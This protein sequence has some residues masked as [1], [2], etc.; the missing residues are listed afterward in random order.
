MA[1]YIFDT[2]T[3]SKDNPEVI[4]AAWIT[5]EDLGSMAVGEQFC[6]RYQPAGRIALGA[7]ATHHIMDEDLA[8]CPPSSSFALPGDI[9]YLVGHN[10][11][12]DWEVAGC[13]EVK[14]ID[15]LAL[16][17]EHYP[18]AD[19]HT[20]SAMLY[21]LDRPNAREKL[22]SAHSA[23]T[24]VLICRDVLAVMLKG[25]L[26]HIDS[27]EELWQA[28][29]EARIPKVMPFGKHKGKR[30]A[31]VPADYRQW[32]LLQPDVDPYLVKALRGS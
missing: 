20:L 32:L 18:E 23:L 30:I 25:P 8:G 17:R 21:L 29:E 12:F 10:I 1:A 22:R 5:I 9:G 28:S 14:R 6:Q 11:D 27:W 4:E 2:E 19:S 3:T 24:D 15:T 7:L 31:D 26:A 16:A 13:P